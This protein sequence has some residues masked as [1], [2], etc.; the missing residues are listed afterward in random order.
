MA[1]TCLREKLVHVAVE[2]F[3]KIEAEKFETVKVSR[4]FPDAIG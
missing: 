3:D 4:V 2:E 1:L